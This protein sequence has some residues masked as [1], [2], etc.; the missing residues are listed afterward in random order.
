ML[1]IQKSRRLQ[2]LLLLFGIITSISAF[3]EVIYEVSIDPGLNEEMWFTSSTLSK[4][5]RLLATLTQSTAVIACN[6]SGGHA[7]TAVILTNLSKD[8]FGNKS[9]YSRSITVHDP[10]VAK[11]YILYTQDEQDS[12]KQIATSNCSKEGDCNN[13]DLMA[14]YPVGPVHYDGQKAYFVIKK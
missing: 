7:G 5:C 11:S 10:A 2:G 13:P 14:G 1:L 3:A 4:K 8:I 12:G 6:V 9:V